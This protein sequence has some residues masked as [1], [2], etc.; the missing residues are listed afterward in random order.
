MLDITRDT[1]IAEAAPYIKEEH[2]K[3]LMEKAE[4]MPLI[5]PVY[6]YTV[7]EF[8]EALDEDHW[9]EFVK[10]PNKPLMQALGELKTFNRQL[11]EI[12][13]VM[14]VNSPKLSSDEEAAKRG[15]VFPSAGESILIEC[16][17]WFHLHSL[18]EAEN[19]KLSNYLIMRRGKTADTL[20]ERNLMKITSDKA[21]NGK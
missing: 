1:T 8:V 18:D 20:F 13:K 21:K 9:K 11:S 19:I 3:E 15:V 4:E 12:V 6:G 5:P 17:E 10:D 7:G 16:C 2:I 14:E